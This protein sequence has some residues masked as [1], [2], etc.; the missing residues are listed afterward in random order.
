MTERFQKKIH[1]KT[2][3]PTKR[4]TTSNFCADFLKKIKKSSTKFEDSWISETLKFK[5]DI[6]PGIYSSQFTAFRHIKK[7]FAVGRLW[8]Y[9]GIWRKWF[10][11]FY[12]LLTM[13]KKTW[14]K[15]VNKKK[16]L[17]KFTSLSFEALNKL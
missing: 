1:W 10:V 4:F 13:Q 8:T 7:N 2:T 6:N 17:E 5:F 11:Y 14:I 9:R 3:I 15:S 12:V 16:K